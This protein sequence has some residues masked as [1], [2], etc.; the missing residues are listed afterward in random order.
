M[1]GRCPA[2]EAKLPTH[3][4]YAAVS[5]PMLNKFDLAKLLDLTPVAVDKR[6]AEALVAIRTFTEA[7]YAAQDIQREGEPELVPDQLQEEINEVWKGSYLQHFHIVDVWVVFRFLKTK[8]ARELSEY[9]DSI[10]RAVRRIRR[11]EEELE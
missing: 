11:Y 6:A 8:I 5:K 3:C 1:V 2:H 7:Y 10:K 9:D 4:I